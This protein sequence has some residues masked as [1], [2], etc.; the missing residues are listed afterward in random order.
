[1]R[2]APENWADIGTVMSNF[3][4]SIEA[5][6][7]EQLKAG[8]CVGGYSG[9]NFHGQVWFEE[10]QFHI[11]VYRHGSHRRTFSGDDLRDLMQDICDEYGRE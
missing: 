10:G 4:D 2:K 3:D 7:V 8:G 5:G 9:W 1:M 6:K 11:A